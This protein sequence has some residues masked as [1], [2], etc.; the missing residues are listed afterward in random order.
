[1][2]RILAAALAL[3]GLLLG[4]QTYRIAGLKEDFAQER[5]GWQQERA[6]ASEAAASASEAYRAREAAWRREQQERIDATQSALDAARTAAAGLPGLN[7]RL[8]NVTSSLGACRRGPA[9][10]SPATSGSAPASEAER[11]LSQLQRES[12]DAE[13]ARTRYAD[14]AAA[15]GE[16]C[17][18]SYEA[19]TR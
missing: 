13:E 4:L 5:A 3:V 14:E 9:I 11:V 16:R 8:R 18:A 12:D 2:T 6:Q 10:D 7:E 19:L 1:V 17:A 15:A